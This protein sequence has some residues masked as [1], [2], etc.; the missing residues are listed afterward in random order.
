MLPSRRT[1]LV[2]LA[3]VVLAGTLAAAA[4]GLPALVVAAFS[5]ATPGQPPPASYERISLD[6]DGPPTRYTVVRDSSGTPVVKAFAHNAATSLGKRLRIDLDEYP[7][8]EWRWKVEDV[9]EAG[10]VTKKSGDDYPARVYVTFDYDPAN[11][12]FFEKVKYRT[13]KTLG[14][15]DIPLR[16]ISYIWASRAPVGEIVANPYTDWVMMVPV[17]S[18]CTHCGT[19]RTERRNVRADYRAAFGEDPPP[20]NGVAI[21]TDTDH[22]GE[23]ATAYYGDIRFL[24]E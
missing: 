11:L 3:A 12:G 10:D 6:D 20:V 7:V 23:K 19:W 17:E 24:Q 9:L 15:D 22:T 18:G 16:A 8:L 13:L 14:Y 21:M 5:E 1:V 2:G 4:P